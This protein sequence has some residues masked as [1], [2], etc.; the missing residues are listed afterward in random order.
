MNGKFNGA[1][2]DRRLSPESLVFNSGSIINV[3]SEVSKGQNLNY[4]WPT[5]NVE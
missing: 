3:E 4:T 2:V 1:P 5:F